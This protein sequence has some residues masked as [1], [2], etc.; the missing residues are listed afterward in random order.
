MI[1]TEPTYLVIPVEQRKEAFRAAGKLPDGGNALTFDD[2]AKSWYANPGADLSKLAK[3]RIDPTLAKPAKQ[4]DAKREFQD[5]I[6]SLGGVFDRRDMLEMDGKTHRIAMQDDKPGKKSGVYVGHLNGFINGWF[7][8]HR[9]GGMRHTWSLATEKPDPAVLA[10]QKALAAQ[11]RYKRNEEIKNEQNIVA[12][13]QSRIYAQLSQAS[14]D[15]PYLQRKM[16]K[17]SSGVRLDRQGNL[18]IPLSNV[19]GEIRSLQTIKPDGAKMLTKNGQKEECFFVVGGTLKNGSPIVMAEG[20]ATAASGAMAL[21][22]PVVMTVDSGNLVK[23]AGALKNKYPDSPMIFL[24]DDDLPKPK[25]PGNPGKE[26]AEEAAALTGGMV[27]LPTFSPEERQQE[28]TDFNDLHIA[29]GLAALSEQLSPVQAM[30]KPTHQQEATMPN[31][32]VVPEMTNP[33][34]DHVANDTETVAIPPVLTDEPSEPTPNVAESVSDQALPNHVAANVQNEFTDYSHIADAVMENE[35]LI[36]LSKTAEIAPTVIPSPPSVDEQSA[37]LEHKEPVKQAATATI[38]SSEAEDSVTEEPVSFASR[39][40]PRPAVEKEQAAPTSSSEEVDGIHIETPIGSQTRAAKPLDLDA[41]MQQ[42]THE[43]AADGRSVKYLF[44]GEAAFVDHGDRLLMATAQASQNDAMILSALLVAREQYRG[45][46]ELT[47]SDE[48]KQ[49][50]I[51]LI[52]EYNLDLKMKNAQQQVMLEEARQ[53]LTDEPAPADK[54]SPVGSPISAIVPDAAEPNKSS[55]SM[56]SANALPPELQ[57]VTLPQEAAQNASRAEGEAGLT[58]TLLDHG[59]AKYN[60]DNSESNSYYIK[61]RTAD[62]EKFVWGKELSRVVPESG[63]AK[64]DIVK[65]IWLGRKE[66]TVEAKMRDPQGKVVV[67]KHGVEQTE[68]ITTHRNHWEIKPAIDPSLL[69]RNEQQLVPPAVLYA[70]DMT[71]YHALQQQVIQMAT[72]AKLPIPPMPTLQHE[73]VWLKPNGEG[74]EPPST[75]PAVT[76]LPAHTQDAGTA[77]IKTLDTEKQ[78]KLLLI[79]GLGDYVQGM[80]KYQDAYHPV[81]GKLCTHTNG[82]RYLTLNIIT[83]EGLTPIGHG[84]AINNEEGASNAFVF[85]LKGEKERLY[86]P[87]VEP[88][89]CPP[90]LHKQLGFTREYTP[91]AHTPQRRDDVPENTVKPATA[92][93]RPGA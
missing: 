91:P 53:R 54:P 41:L 68:Q 37:S 80:V 48:F 45:R 22:H 11:E 47:G 36:E 34:P 3:W 32:P 26:K 92:F 55:V 77:L 88:A 71:H 4:G 21:H 33:E 50:A 58:G 44:A 5:F 63:L 29:H 40:A 90:A 8:D 74:T 84:N 38:S 23:V 24:A 60:F 7:A 6:E 65:L 62:G 52:A 43:M 16:V 42:I 85:N 72:E 13:T 86:A 46:I 59:Q 28:L 35:A 61:L 81:L 19:D 78:L 31:T 75:R 76:P 51:T 82:H 69:V 10:H 14:H 27:L 64:G 89:K 17:A 15:H 9:D 66:V 2:E 12:K 1:A 93:P 39:L 67:D 49:R 18:K 87:L 56:Q 73:L 25:R 20:Y 57:P 83:P 79:K 70:Y 30:L